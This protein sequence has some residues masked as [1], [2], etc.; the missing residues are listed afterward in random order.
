MRR[1]ILVVGIVVV[2]VLSLF[3]V[4]MASESYVGA[5]YSGAVNHG[6]TTVVDHSVRWRSAP[7]N[8]RVVYIAV[9]APNPYGKYIEAALVKAAR[10]DGLRPVPVENISRYDL[11]GRVVIAYFPVTGNSEWV[12]SQERYVSGFLYYS[13]AGD[14][15]SAVKAV[16][17]GLVLSDDRIDSSAGKICQMSQ[18]RLISMKIVNTSCTVAYWWNL[19]AKVGKISG[20]NPYMMIA[21]EI[22]SQFTKMLKDSK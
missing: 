15:K 11:K 10:A 8:P 20:G 14:V 2:L 18:K 13:Y 3:G 17:G 16:N 12:F 21:S 22:A 5:D 19:K 7:Q 9:W 1:V 4:V 6:A